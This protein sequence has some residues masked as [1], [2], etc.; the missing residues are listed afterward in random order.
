M[1]VDKPQKVSMKMV[2]ITEHLRVRHRRESTLPDVLA[3]PQLQPAGPEAR[4]F[5]LRAHAK[6]QGHLA[7]AS[8]VLNLKV[9]GRAG[10]HP[11]E[12]VVQEAISRG[13]IERR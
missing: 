3:A 10:T 6:P 8:P 11:R 13:A 7:F 2:R 1:R 5:A 9:N 4:R 12:F